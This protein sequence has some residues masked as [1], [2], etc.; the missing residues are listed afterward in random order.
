[1][2]QA[3]TRLF[4]AVRDGLDAFA[5]ALGAIRQHGEQRLSL[6]MNRMSSAM[7]TLWDGA[8]IS[9]LTMRKKIRPGTSKR[10][11]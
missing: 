2:T 3:G 10:M 5:T 4:P 8:K 9:L 7:S 11:K 6:C 1:L